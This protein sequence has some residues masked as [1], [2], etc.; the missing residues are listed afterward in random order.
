MDVFCGSYF[1]GLTPHLKYV[2]TISFFR[3]SYINFGKE[4]SM[5]PPRY[6]KTTVNI[7]RCVRLT[8]PGIIC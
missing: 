4:L 8:A 2:F 1:A 3:F 6:S 7:S 5:L